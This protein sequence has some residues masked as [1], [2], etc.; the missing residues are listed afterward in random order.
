MGTG[1]AGAWAIV[2]KTATVLVLAIATFATL[3][4]CA[5]QGDAP[6]PSATSTLQAGLP[7]TAPTAPVDAGKVTAAPEAT[8]DSQQKAIAAAAKVMQAFAQP[9][10][11]A[12]Q[13]W[14]QMLPLLSQQGGVAYEGTDPSQ[15]PAHQVTGAGTV[16]PDSTEVSLIVQLPTDAGLYSVT[17]TRPDASSPW[18]ADRIRPAQ[19]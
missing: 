10:L 19:G 15:I 8:G 4:G 3:T 9:Q 17:L 7:S 12:D 18:L 16:L 13:W 6:S 5:D 1:H 2:R 11:S 14:A